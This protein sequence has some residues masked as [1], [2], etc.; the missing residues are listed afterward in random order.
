MAPSKSFHVL[1][2]GPLMSSST[3]SFEYSESLF[4]ASPTSS[5]AHMIAF[6]RAFSKRAAIPKFTREVGKAA[7]EARDALKTVVMAGQYHFFVVSSLLSTLGLRFGAL[8]S[9]SLYPCMSSNYVSCKHVQATTSAERKMEETLISKNTR[10]DLGAVDSTAGQWQEKRYSTSMGQTVR[11]AK[12][13]WWLGVA[14]W[15][16]TQVRSR[17][18]WRWENSVGAFEHRSGRLR[19]KP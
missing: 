19:S 11:R 7:G 13:G 8:T 3:S 16:T 12:R 10:G 5:T 15:S 9:P 4:S 6:E 14:S 2:F 18:V 17:R 1:R